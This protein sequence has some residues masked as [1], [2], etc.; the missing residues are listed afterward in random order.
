MGPRPC[1]SAGPRDVRFAVLNA[2]Q[3]DGRL[4]EDT[5]SLVLEHEADVARARERAGEIVA[6]AQ[7]A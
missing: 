5:L 3:L 6:A 7:L 1:K 2:E 4:L